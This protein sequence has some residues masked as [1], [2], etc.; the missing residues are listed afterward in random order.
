MRPN[1]TERILALWGPF[2]M[3]SSELVKAKRR[4]REGRGADEEVD[5][6][7]AERLDIAN[8]LSELGSWR[9]LQTGRLTG[10]KG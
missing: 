5:W 10:P 9:T 6:L 8:D 7:R 1:P 4:L 2:D 3:I